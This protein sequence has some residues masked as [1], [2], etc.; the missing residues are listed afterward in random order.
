VLLAIAILAVG[1]RLAW[2]N[3]IEY[4]VVSAYEVSADGRTLTA[5]F[6]S[7]HNCD[8]QL[9]AKTHETEDA[10]VVEIAFHKFP[11]GAVHDDMLR[12]CREV[13]QLESPLGRRAV[14][15]PG[16]DLVTTST[17]PATP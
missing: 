5:E 6:G 3:S 17:L 4:A 16:G 12:I 13:F 10:V 8:E 9:F 14:T 2:L 11:P 1:A 15:M 7:A